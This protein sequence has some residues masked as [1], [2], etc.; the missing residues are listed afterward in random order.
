MQ[1][2][3]SH[4]D[5]I[6]TPAALF[7]CDA[8]SAGRIGWG[9]LAPRNPSLPSVVILLVWP[10]GGVGRPDGVGIAFDHYGG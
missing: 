9:S 6:T 8:V 5:M 1:S 10:S 7:L 2:I 3:I 4:E